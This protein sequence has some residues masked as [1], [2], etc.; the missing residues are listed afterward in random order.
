M[1][2][3]FRG[4]GEGT[5][6]TGTYVFDKKLRKFVLISDRAPNVA[7][8][9][10]IHGETVS[11]KPGGETIDLGVGKVYRVNDAS[12]KRR[13]LKENGVMP[14]PTGMKHT[15][16]EIKMPSFGEYFHKRHGMPLKEATGLVHKAG[17]DS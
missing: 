4:V 9:T 6:Q 14:A 10:S 17:E 5:G 15:R 12:E 11:C 1:A 16:K 13:V 7:G 2:T 3:F 8:I